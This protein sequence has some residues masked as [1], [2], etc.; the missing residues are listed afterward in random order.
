[1]IG[2]AARTAADRG[3]FDLRLL[4][5]ESWPALSGGCCLTGVV[6]PVVALFKNS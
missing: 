5:G 4:P 1:V 6:A 2:L 3:S